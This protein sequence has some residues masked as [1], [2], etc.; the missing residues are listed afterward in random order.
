MCKY[1]TE[2]QTHTNT[3]RDDIRYIEVRSSNPANN[4][5]TAYIT[6]YGIEKYEKIFRTKRDLTDC[7]KIIINSIDRYTT[8]QSNFKPTCKLWARLHE[9]ACEAEEHVERLQ[10]NFPRTI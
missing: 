10:S 9:L 3:T 4:R 5:R 1:E 8:L 6:F 2:S 7:V